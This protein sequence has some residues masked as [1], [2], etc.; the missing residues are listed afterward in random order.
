M[1]FWQ[2]HRLACIIGVNLVLFTVTFLFATAVRPETD[3]WERIQVACLIPTF[4]NICGM[5]W[6]IIDVDYYL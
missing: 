4:V 3:V 1:T 6:N 2:R 5:A